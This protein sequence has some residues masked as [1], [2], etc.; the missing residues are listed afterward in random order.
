MNK[1]ER[2]KLL[3]ET[4]NRR[5]S[6]HKS[7]EESM[8]ML[9]QT[10]AELNRIIA[11]NTKNAL[12]QSSSSDYSDQSLRQMK[13]DLEKDFN[14]KLETPDVILTGES[15][16]EVFAKIEKEVKAE[17]VGQDEAVKALCIAFRRPYVAGSDPNLIRTSFILTGKNGTGRH[18]LI[19]SI[20]KAMKK[21]GL[22]ITEDVV[23][24]D[25]SRYQSAAQEMLFLQDLYVALQG[26]NA[27]IV[28]E[29]YGLASSI[30]L[31]MLS[32]LVLEGSCRLNKRYTFVNG[33]L[34]EASSKL[35]RE[36]IDHLDGNN[37][38]LAFVG[39]GSASR[40]T[41]IFG[42]SFS[43]R[44]VDKI[45]TVTL[46]DTS[47]RIIITRMLAELAQKCRGQLKL[48]VTIDESVAEMFRQAYQLEDGI[49]SLT[50]LS[51]KIY[52]QLVEYALR[53]ESTSAL[54]LLWQ[55]KKLLLHTENTAI[56][57]HLG[58]DTEREMV[59]IQKEL[60]NIVGLQKV[61]EYLLSL[62]N[63]V[64]VSLMRKKQGLKVAQVSKH[65]IFTGNPGTGKTTIARLISRMMKA[66]GV[67][68]QGQLVEVTRADLVGKYV[69]HTAPLTMSVI[70]SALGGVLFIDEAYSLYRGKDDSFG[71]EA[72]DTLVKAMEDHRD[73][74][75]V[76]LAGYSHEM[77]E[78]LTANTGLRSRFANIIHFPDYSGEELMKIAVVIARSKDYRIDETVL[79]S[80]Q[81]YFTEKQAQADMASG[82]GRMARN[83]VEDAILHHSERMLKDPQVEIDLL[84][85]EDFNLQ[86]NHE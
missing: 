69:G 50:P 79:P 24:L 29:N 20:V 80:L 30:Y 66:S 52:E 3:A 1:E 78:F 68:K 83:L 36:S 39:E 40:L 55:E 74:F 43:D 9:R 81:N 25:M 41:D 10:E 17:V 65:M 45:E 77:E 6:Y 32:E 49:D 31:R 63:H 44:I 27:V 85:R 38:I 71:L 13:T 21:H 34:Q 23:R 75:I 14:A 61:K 54:R 67:L 46:D 11:E 12:H 26:K 28:I 58:D 60:D 48:D 33:Q 73:D 35:T 16:R 7:Y 84:R 57:L 76:I 15:S 86:E 37:K 8:D 22:L 62:Q 4:L 18:Q 51:D 42:K 64:K 19:T 59:A 47:L 82:N 5:T 2:E 70:E 72:I 53:H 56:T